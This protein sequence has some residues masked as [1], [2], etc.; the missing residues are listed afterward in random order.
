LNIGIIV[1]F[2][3]MLIIGKVTEQTRLITSIVFCVA[4]GLIN[5]GYMAFSGYKKGAI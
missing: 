4:V 2:I 5:I 3:I 1:G